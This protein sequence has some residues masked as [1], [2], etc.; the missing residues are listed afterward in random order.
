MKT[1]KRLLMV[2][3]LLVPARFAAGDDVGVADT[4][5]WACKY[6]PF[7]K[8]GVEGGLELGLGYVSQD[9]YKFGEYNA[10]NE[11]GVFL[12]GDA[13]LRLRGQ[14]AHYWNVEARN[15]GLDS[16]SLAVQGG[17]QGAYKLSFDYAELP[18]FISD[19]IR[20][21][22]DG[23]GSRALSLPATWVRAPSSDTMSALQGSLHDEKLQTSRKRLGLGAALIA[24]SDWQYAVHFQQERREGQQAVSGSFLF[25]SAQLVMPVDYLTQQLDVS[26]SYTGESLQARLA[27]YGSLFSEDNTALTWQN[28]YSATGGADSAQL[29][30]APD[31]QFHQIMASAGYDVTKTTRASAQIALGRMT[32]NEAFLDPTLNTTLTD[33][34]FDLP[35]DSL[36]GQVDTVNVAVNVVA[37]LTAQLRM[38]LAYVYDDHDDKTPQASYTWVSS[39][40]LVNASTRTNLPYSFKK[41]SIKW[42][43]RYRVAARTRFSIGIDHDTQERRYQAVSE[44]TQN[45]YWGKVKTRGPANVEATLR[46][47]HAV[48][49]IG[50][51]EALAWLSMAENPL[52]RKYNMADRNRDEGSLRID[53]LG[54]DW[55]SAGFGVDYANDDYTE[56]VIGLTQSQDTTYSADTA[57]TLSGKTSVYAFLT[58]EKIDS[59]QAGSALGGVPDWRARNN[60]VSDTLGAGVKHTL[61]DKRLD[62]GLDY[63]IARSRGEVQVDAGIADPGFPAIRTDL[64]STRLYAHYTLRADLL[65]KGAYA[66]EHFDAEDWALDGVAPDSVSN[67]LAFG[68]KPP[69][70]NLHVLTMS[71]RYRF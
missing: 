36:A 35:R 67:V 20:S 11:Q 63:N 54:L 23:V 50:T 7:E 66:Y 6:C 39:D 43:A 71:L 58:H 53:W 55:M 41:S 42:D 19:S 30:L 16:R 37:D 3:I 34:P 14:N 40:T 47:A 65:L 4:F 8:P 46:L 48:R 18:H 70:Y 17:Q 60:D 52:L 27:Y 44:T 9:T 64:R 13:D 10:L 31:N 25:N 12:I 29:A 5:N 26:A 59:R 69:S 1:S 24:S 49:D 51:Y 68:E 56:S 22:F 21:V 38:H 57:L 15:L 45:S 62:V 28:P 2:F 61:I 32:Q 33:Y